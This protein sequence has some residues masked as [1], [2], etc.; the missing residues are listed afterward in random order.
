MRAPRILH[1]DGRHRLTLFRGHAPSARAVLCFEA[2][3]DVMKGFAPSHCPGFAERLGIDALTVQTARRDWFLSPGS[4]ALADAMAAATADYAEVTATGFSMG[5]Y[6]VLLYSRAARVSRCLLVSPQ[7]SIDPRIAPYD[8]ARHTK[9]R[10]MNHPMPRPEDWGDTGLRGVLLYD[11]TIR[12]DRAHAE[13]IKAA[14]PRLRLLGLPYGGHPCTGVIADAGKIG[15]V[16]TMLVEARMHLGAIRQFHRE[17]RAASHRY[18]L[19]LARE[20][21]PRHPDRAAPELLRLAQE[22]PDSIRFE[23]GMALFAHQPDLALDLLSRLVDEARNPPEHWGRR[24]RE[25]LARAPDQPIPAGWDAGSG[26]SS[27]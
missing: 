27:E 5:G 22:G 14:F 18:R 10:R 9:F 7:Y 26:Q 16:S 17:G 19:H 23:A 25:A 1:D 24:I 21:L 4:R 11:P 6:A 3:R 20:A 2:G 15:R 12:A 8:T 13:R